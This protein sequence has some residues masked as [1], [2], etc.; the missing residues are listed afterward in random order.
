MPEGKQWTSK[1]TEE[2]LRLV[3][4]GESWEDIGKKLNRTA[5]A[6][7][8]KWD[9]PTSK[10]WK[11]RHITGLASR[12][13][14]Q[15]PPPPPLNPPPPPPIQLVPSATALYNTMIGKPK[16]QQLIAMTS[17]REVLRTIPSAKNELELCE[18]LIRFIT[19]SGN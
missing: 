13:I 5:I 15:S 4:A 3:Q 10:E 7:R 9:R 2:F 12:M 16:G 18:A 11:R 6:C 1:E 19:S 14:E 17:L 8:S